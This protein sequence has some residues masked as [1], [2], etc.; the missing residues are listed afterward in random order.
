MNLLQYTFKKK[1]CTCMICAILSMYYVN[2]NWLFMIYSAVCILYIYII[3]YIDGVHINVQTSNCICKKL[4]AYF[5]V[6]YLS[7]LTLWIFVVSIGCPKSND[8]VG[9]LCC[10]SLLTLSSWIFILMFSNFQIKSPLNC[11]S[12]NLIMWYL[13][14]ALWRHLQ[15]IYMPYLDLG[16]HKT[17]PKTFK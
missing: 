8:R 15:F 1:K 4:H 9:Y 3:Q 5:T 7:K 2:V 14:R 6:G 16:R 11:P 17:M 13:H 10:H 12:K